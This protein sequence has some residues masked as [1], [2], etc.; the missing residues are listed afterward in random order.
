[1][2]RGEDLKYILPV[3][4]YIGID[5]LRVVITTRIHYEAVVGVHI[6][7]LV[8]S[9]IA[10]AKTPCRIPSCVAG[11]TKAGNDLLLGTVR[12]RIIHKMSDGR[13]TLAIVV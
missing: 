9:M 11:R 10:G 2:R 8:A 3:K 5:G 1:M 4:V 12:G 6:P 13:P 7:S